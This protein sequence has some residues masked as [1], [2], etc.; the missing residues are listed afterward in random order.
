M[1]TLDSEQMTDSNV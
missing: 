1:N